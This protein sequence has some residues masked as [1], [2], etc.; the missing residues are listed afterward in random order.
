M[1]YERL[2]SPQMVVYDVPLLFEKAMEQMVDITILVYAP[3]TIQKD[4]LMKR[5]HI[6]GELAETILNQQMD[7]E[8]KKSKSQFIIENTKSE[9][10]LLKEVE[11]FLQ[12]ILE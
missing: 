12:K 4:R 3:R 10:E 1:A 11:T 6:S 2:S 9:Q 5:D 7:I 8:S